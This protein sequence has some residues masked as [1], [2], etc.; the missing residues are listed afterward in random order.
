M[1]KDMLAARFGR[2]SAQPT[3][4]PAAGAAAPLEEMN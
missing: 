1:L 2:R 4:V 3:P